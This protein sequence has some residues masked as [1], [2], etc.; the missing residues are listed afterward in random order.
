MSAFDKVIGYRGIKQELLQVCDMMQHREVYDALGAKMPRGMLLYGK[1]GLGKTLLASC[2]IAESGR[3]AFT[4]RRDTGGDAFL[5]RIR[6]AFARA[7]EQAPTI[8]FLDDMDKFANEDR[9]RRDAPEYVAVQACIDD[10]KG[11]EVFVLATANDI[12]K[13]PDSLVRSGRFDI[14]LKV[15]APDGKDSE[16]IIR[17]YLR[18][19][20][21]AGDLN[22]EDLTKMVSYS[23]CADLEQTLNDAAIHAAFHK[24]SR[25]GIEDFVEVILRDKLDYPEDFF[26]EDDDS[27]RK[28]A[29]HEAGHLVAAEV[30]Y[31]GSVGMAAIRNEPGSGCNG[32]VHMC[33]EIP[34]TMGYVRIAM[35]GKAAVE[36]YYA[37]DRAGGCEDDLLKASHIIE[38]YIS[39]EAGRGFGLFRPHVS[40]TLDISDGMSDRM[41]AIVQ[42]EMERG[43]FAT[44]NILLKN[45][46]FLE[47]V[48]DALMEKK[49]L[50]HSDIR[51]I[52]ERVSVTDMRA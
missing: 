41:L 29:L 21:V 50:L 4:L 35:A 52:R 28:T 16:D 37:E 9:G 20:Q 26:R 33:R 47:A 45:R 17:Y 44:K 25:I 36:Q 15:E 34:E 14:R 49:A 39:R 31:P 10:C 51:A 5:E 32:F 30:L 42:A 43:F 38:D 24:R 40:R 8:V 19:K 1:P 2:L 11:Q 27:I 3:K 13:L 12:D 46:A 22:F 7:R 23:S 18:D 48:A 6:D